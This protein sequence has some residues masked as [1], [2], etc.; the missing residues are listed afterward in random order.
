MTIIGFRPDV[1]VEC[2]VVINEGSFHVDLN[3]LSGHFP[4]DKV[5]SSV[6][7]HSKYFLSSLW[8]QRLIN[9]NI[10]LIRSW[11]SPIFGQITK[12]NGVLVS[13]S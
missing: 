5:C 2:L 13:P 10:F 6:Y 11:A 8:N 9:Y 1:S 3:Q 4:R 7:S 12:V